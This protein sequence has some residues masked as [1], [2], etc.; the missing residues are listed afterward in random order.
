MN[1]QDETI[2][3]LTESVD[4]GYFDKFRPILDKYML[5]E[6]EGET[7]ASQ[8]VTAINKLIYKW[9]NDGDVFDNTHYLEGWANDLS[10]YTNWLYE[11][12]EGAK[13]VLDLIE[14]CKTDDD[15]ERLLKDLADEFLIEDILKEFAMEAKVG[16]IYE[17]DGPF[18]FSEYQ[19]ED[20]DDY[21][22][23]EE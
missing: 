22:D 7:K 16:S 1:I 10:D 3:A 20:E 4:W 23:E 11:N 5:D 19:E 17:C 13:A 21:E 15:Y 14:D 12:V 18:E 8:T 9:Y 6:G 2:K